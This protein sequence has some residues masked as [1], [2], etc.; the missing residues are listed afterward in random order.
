MKTFKAGA[1]LAFSGGFYGNDDILDY[2]TD[3]N[4]I[5]PTTDSE[6]PYAVVEKDDIKFNTEIN[7]KRS[8]KATLDLNPDVAKSSL[9]AEIIQSGPKD[10]EIDTSALGK[11]T[12][13]ITPVEG[14]IPATVNASGTE[15]TFT[16]SEIGRAIVEV[17]CDALE[18]V[19][20]AEFDLTVVDSTKGTGAAEDGITEVKAEVGETAPPSVS[21]ITE[22]QKS[23]LETDSKTAVDNAVDS[24]C[25]NADVHS[26]TVE[27]TVR[28]DTIDNVPAP[29]ENEKIVLG[30]SQTLNN[31]SL[32]A[33]TQ[34]DEDGNIIS[35][36]P[37][38]RSVTYE[39]VPTYQMLTTD[40]QPVTETTVFDL[41]KGQVRMTF[42]IPVP[43]SVTDR[44]ARVEHISD[45]YGTSTG[46]Y[47]VETGDNGGKYITYTTDHFSTFKLTFTNDRPSG[48]GSHGGS[49]KGSPLTSR[50][51][52]YADGTVKTNDG[53][54]HEDEKGWWFELPD[55]TW[56]VSMWR[57]CPWNGV[58]NWY[59]FNAE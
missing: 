37:V 18:D 46:Y 29:S 14:N 8:T 9:T 6:Y 53:T 43:S 35:V 41:I 23:Q 26:S 3:G 40:G 58:M 59:H 12:W 22:E 39:I 16:A 31:V 45:D 57:E 51:T 28:T 49:S 25:N 38:I 5:I 44:Y 47:T 7:G 1:Q 10:V 11:Y 17:S 19:I 4:L 30:T 13:T 15:A 48:G 56:P 52:Y 33:V 20:L 55:G 2:I 21:G 36:A 24:V 34:T 54:W 50:A 42:R 27:T 32:E